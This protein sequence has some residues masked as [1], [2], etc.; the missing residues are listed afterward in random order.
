MRAGG[1]RNPISFPL[2]FLCPTLPA[3]RMASHPPTNSCRKASQPSFALSSPACRMASHT[4]SNAC[5]RASRP[6]LL[7]LTLPLP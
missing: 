2:P 1:H 4:P 3:C 5:R 7:S 6:H